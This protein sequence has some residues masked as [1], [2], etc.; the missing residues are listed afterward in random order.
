[1]DKKQNKSP[2]PPSPPLNNRAF[3]RFQPPLQPKP[4]IMTEG[5]NEMLNKLQGFEYIPQE[6]I[7]K[8]ICRHCLNDLTHAGWCG[9]CEQREFVRNWQKWDSGSPEVNSIIEDTQFKTKNMFTF[10][11][12]IPPKKIYRIPGIVGTGGTGIVTAALWMDGPRKSVQRECNPRSGPT[13]VALKAFKNQK[14]FIKELTAIKQWLLHFNEF[15]EEDFE[16]A[17]KYVIR[18]YGV[19]FNPTTSSYEL[20][21][22]LVKDGTLREYLDTKWTLLSWPEKLRLT[23]DLALALQLFHKRNL[24]HGDLHSG[25][26]L[27]NNN[28]PVIIDLAQCRTAESSKSERPPFGLVP[29]VAPEVWCRAPYTTAADIYSFAVIMFELATGCRPFGGTAHGANL[30]H[31]VIQ[32]KRPT[33]AYGSGIPNRYVDLIYNNW[34]H[35]PEKRHTVDQILIDICRWYG[36]LLKKNDFEIM[37]DFYKA[38]SRRVKMLADSEQTLLH[39]LGGHPQATYTSRL[40]DDTTLRR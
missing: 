20:V 39:I 24:V 1:M 15:A 4:P 16:R 21:F 18:C 23:K 37:E 35:D 25:N 3:F 19:T 13:N 11:E 28:V 7:G 31:A 29:Y 36:A 27:M 8:S 14:Y 6:E 26:I 40:L 30:R 12:W 34:G 32:G 2:S 22:Q 17:L 9:G 33:I 10:L 5:E 38:E